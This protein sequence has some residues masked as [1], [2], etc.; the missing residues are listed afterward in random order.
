MIADVF[1]IEIILLIFLAFVPACFSYFLDNTLGYP[2]KDDGPNTKAI[3][4]PYTLKMATRRLTKAQYNALVKNFES[5]LNSDDPDQRAD[6][7]RLLDTS[8]VIQGRKHF[9]WEMAF[10]MCIFCTG[11]WIALISAF[12]MFWQVEFIAIFPPFVFIIIP[13]FSHTILRKLSK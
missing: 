3:F 9:T 4:F 12:I 13:I 10:G 1:L 7:K 6:G 2:G 5:L 11:F 8:I